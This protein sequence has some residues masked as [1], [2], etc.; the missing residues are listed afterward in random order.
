MKPDGGTAFPAFA[1]T[2]V[3]SSEADRA[4]HFQP[5]PTGGMTLRDYFAGQALSAVIAY[6][7]RGLAQEDA[8][9]YPSIAREAYAIAD[10]MLAEREKEQP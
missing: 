7:D 9:P 8:L 1:P 3:Y 6:E 4:G 5:V 10:A 2:L